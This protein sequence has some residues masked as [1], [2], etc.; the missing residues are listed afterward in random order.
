MPGQDGKNGI[1]GTRKEK[2]MTRANL[3]NRGL[4]PCLFL[5][6]CSKPALPQLGRGSVTGIVTDSTGGVIAGV[7]I[8]AVHVQTRV[9]YRTTSNQTGNYLITS[10]PIGEYEITWSGQGFKQLNRTGLSLVS[11]QVAR[12]DVTLEVGQITEK[13]SVTA[14]APLLQTETENTSNSVNSRVFFTLPLTFVGG[15]DITSFAGALVPG[16][17]GD[18]A[19]GTPSKTLA[20]V[21]DGMSNEAGFLPGEFGQDSISPEAIEELTVF[22][23]YYIPVCAHNVASPLGTMASA[24]CAAAIR[25]FRGHEWN[26]GSLPNEEAWEKYVVSDAPLLKDGRIQ[27]PDKPGIGLELNEDYVRQHLAPGEQWWG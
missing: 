9:S 5:V 24:Y 14:E 4:W 16:V 11:G 8:I 21:V 19:Q 23:G 6:L 13:L 1:P 27:I 25:D 26:R 17:N 7:E 22:T 3:R 20:T 10:L 2:I 18:K 15:R 12:L